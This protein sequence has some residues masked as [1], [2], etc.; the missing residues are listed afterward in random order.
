MAYRVPDVFEELM[1]EA[2]DEGKH[3]V[4]RFIRDNRTGYLPSPNSH[5]LVKVYDHLFR[6]ALE[7]NNNGFIGFMYETG[8]DNAWTKRAI[9]ESC[10]TETVE[11]VTDMFDE[12]WSMNDLVYASSSGC[13][14]FI[15]HVMNNRLVD[16]ACLI[17][18]RECV[19]AAVR[20]G[21]H[22]LARYL[23]HDC[24]FVFKYDDIDR[25]TE[26]ALR[27]RNRGLFKA[28]MDRTYDVP[29]V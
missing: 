21:H 8:R 15:Q 5:T 2:K 29:N 1:Q 4:V 6:R 14:E 20:G 9:V 11:F 19:A 16:T 28:V 17:L 25:I 10:N 24:G 18:Q 26:L 13:L 27:K 23:I 7:Q 3:G 12:S 22:E